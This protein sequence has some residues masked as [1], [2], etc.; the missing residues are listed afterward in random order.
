[1]NADLS[2]LPPSSPPSQ[3]HSGLSHRLYCLKEGER[4][5]G[6]E[7]GRLRKKREGGREGGLAYLVV[8][9]NQHLHLLPS[10]HGLQTHFDTS[11]VR[12]VSV[13]DLV[14]NWRVVALGREGGGEGREGRE[15]G[16]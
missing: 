8:R 5:E 16:R 10:R 6:R 14:V 11:V 7:R 9:R 4:E 2:I 13:L 1:V 3:S 12:G 15:G